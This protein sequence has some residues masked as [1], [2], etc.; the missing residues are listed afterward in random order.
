[1]HLCGVSHPP[2]KQRREH[3]APVCVRPL[4][5]CWG[6]WILTRDLADLLR[7]P[8]HPACHHRYRRRWRPA[9]ARHHRGADRLQEEVARRWPHPQTAAAA[10]GQPGVQG[11]P[12]VQGRWVWKDF[13]H[14]RGVALAAKTPQSYI[15]IAC[16]LL[17]SFHLSPNFV[18]FIFLPK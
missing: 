17:V 3:N 11:G 6:V 14:Q 10:D 13:G 12:W 7:Q 9:P 18:L 4:G 1:M 15:H 5:A 16:F 2:A 8:P